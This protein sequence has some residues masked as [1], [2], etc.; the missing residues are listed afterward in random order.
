MCEVLTHPHTIFH[1]YTCGLYGGAVTI[2]AALIYY[3][4][5]KVA[6]GMTTRRRRSWSTISSTPMRDYVGSL[7]QLFLHCPTRLVVTIHDLLLSSILGWHSRS[8]TSVAYLYPYSGIIAKSKNIIFTIKQMAKCL[9]FT[10]VSSSR[11]N[12]SL[13]ELVG[14]RCNLK[15]FKKH[16]KMFQHPLIPYRRYKM[17]YH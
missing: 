8:S 7:L 11:K 14:A 2:A 9:S 17:L 15:K 16:P 1:P 3:D 6:A 10:M 4:N 5:V 13:K 12:I